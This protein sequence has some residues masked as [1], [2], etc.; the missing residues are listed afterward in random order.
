MSSFCNVNLTRL[1]VQCTLESGC[2]RVRSEVKLGEFHLVYIP[3]T[4]IVVSQR[5]ISLNRGFI[6]LYIHIHTLLNTMLLIY[7][8]SHV[9]HCLVGIVVKLES[10]PK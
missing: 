2:V 1:E 8:P 9:Q 6:Y 5:A 10:C 3:H 7:V 4:L